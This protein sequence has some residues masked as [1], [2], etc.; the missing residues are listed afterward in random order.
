MKKMI[1]ISIAFALLFSGCS[2]KKYKLFQEEDNVKQNELTIIPNEEYK[3]EMVFENII[4]P[5]DR[6]D[7]T[8]YIQ[9]GQGSQ[10]MTSMLTSRETNTSKHK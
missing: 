2:T 5:N 9:A 7:I 8:V 10:Q 6:V 1:F 4:A 3:K